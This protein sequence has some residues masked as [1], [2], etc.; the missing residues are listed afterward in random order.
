MSRFD[1]AR[2][3]FETAVAKDTVAT[4][5][6]STH[7]ALHELGRDEEAL[8]WMQKIIDK[9]PSDAGNWYDYACL[10]SRMNRIDDAMKALEKAFELGYRNFGHL[11][12]DYDMDTL[13]DLPR[14]KELVDKYRAIHE[15]FLQKSDIPVAEKTEDTISE[16]A[17]TRHV[18]GTFEVPC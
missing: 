5:G 3:D 13:R 7:Y 14:Y 10:Y 9:D 11:E 8:A 16:I 12:Y 18:G 6:S 1:E 4:N 17:F 2:A 15:E